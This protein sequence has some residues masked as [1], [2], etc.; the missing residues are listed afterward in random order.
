MT[1]RSQS[2]APISREEER[3]LAGVLA[4]YLDCGARVGDDEERLETLLNRLCLRNDIR[5]DDASDID[6]EDD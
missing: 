3:T 1:D 6:M 2:L 5:R 4:R